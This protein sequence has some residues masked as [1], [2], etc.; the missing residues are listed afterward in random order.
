MI[1]HFRAHAPESQLS[2]AASVLGDSMG[3]SCDALRLCTARVCKLWSV[4]IGSHDVPKVCHCSCV[5][6]SDAL[7]GPSLHAA[8]WNYPTTE[9]HEFWAGKGG[10]LNITIVCA[11][12]P[13]VY[14]T[15][16]AQDRVVTVISINACD[17]PSPHVLNNVHR[18]KVQA[19]AKLS[20]I[21]K[22]NHRE[23]S[24]VTN[25][26]PAVCLNVLFSIATRIYL[27][28]IK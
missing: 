25:G 24:F 4:C 13:L 1:S 21:R 18:A 5:C 6:C 15:V 2:N 8:C 14:S 28:L 27:K 3:N 20:G 12:K 23:T 17:L 10:G 7:S 26:H 16:L 22:H 11:P 9:T 19:Q